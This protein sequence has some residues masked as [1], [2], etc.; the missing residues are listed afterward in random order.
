MLKSINFPLIALSLLSLRAVIFSASIGDAIGIVAL[1]G[2]VCFTNYLKH[3]KIEDPTKDIRE[4]LAESQLKI[5][6]IKSTVNSLKLARTY[7]K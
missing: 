3:V 1:S 5:E 2:V 4:A 7:G 6:E